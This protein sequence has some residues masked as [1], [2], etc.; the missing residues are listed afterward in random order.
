MNEYE[1]QLAE[2]TKKLNEIELKE[3]TEQK[4]QKKITLFVFENKEQIAANK[5]QKQLDVEKNSPLFKRYNISDKLYRPYRTGSQIKEKRYID[6]FNYILVPREGRREGRVKYISECFNLEKFKQNPLNEI[7][8]ENIEKTEVKIKIDKKDNSDKIILA[9]NKKKINDLKIYA[10]DMKIKGYSFMKKEQLVNSIYEILK[11]KESE[12]EKKETEEKDK[13]EENKQKDKN[14]N[15]KK[16][17]NEILKECD[18]DTTIDYEDDLN[19]NDDNLFFDDDDNND[20]SV[21]YE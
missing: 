9:L 1:K 15:I 3:L 20:D 13:K 17:K 6:M 12:K 10:R 14:V 2:L 18:I 4:E 5:T 8:T 11:Q 16:S 19:G 21:D 7:K